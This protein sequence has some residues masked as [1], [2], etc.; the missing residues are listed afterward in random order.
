M[1]IHG[2]RRAARTHARSHTPADG[3]RVEPSSPLRT[4]LVVNAPLLGVRQHAIRFGRAPI[5]RSRFGYVIRLSREA[6]GMEA[7]CE[8]PEPE[9]DGIDIRVSGDTE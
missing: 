6:I 2:G 1:L 3:I 9:L 5:H 8:R 7:T 4:L